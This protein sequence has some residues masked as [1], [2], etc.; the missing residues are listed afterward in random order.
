MRKRY[1]LFSLLI[2][3]AS[4]LFTAVAAAQIAVRIDV[5]DMQTTAQSTSLLLDVYFSVYDSS[6][7]SAPQ[8]QVQS[9]QILL[10]NGDVYDATV[11]RPPFY[12]ALLFDSSGSMKDVLP[13]MQEAGRQIINAAPAEAQFAVIQFDE[14]IV[15]QQTFTNDAAA[16][17]DAI[18]QI[19]VN[20]KGTCLYDGL[21][22]AVQSISQIAQDTPRQAV[23]VFTD[24]RDERRQGAG[25]SCSQN[26][27]DQLVAFAANRRRPVPI[28]P[29]GVAPAFGQLD[30]DILQGLATASGGQFQDGTKGLTEDLFTAILADLN[31]LW[32][33]QANLYP[34]QGSHR[35][36]LL[37]T[38]NDG[39]TPLPA[40]VAFTAERSYVTPPEPVTAVI[41]NFMYDN[42]SNSYFFDVS[43]TGY[44]RVAKIGAEVIDADTNQQITRITPQDV[45]WETE[46]VVVDA[47]LLQPDHTY[48]MRVQPLSSNGKPIRNEEVDG[49]IS[50]AATTNDTVTEVMA[51]YPFR[52]EPQLPLTMH[53]DS[54][55]I[56][57]D[58]PQINWQ[59][60]QVEDEPAQLTLSLFLENNDQVVQ[61]DGYILDNSNNQQIQTF[62]LT[63]LPDN[64]AQLP[65]QTEKTGTYT[66]VI[67]AL[68]ENGTRLAT[69]E[70]RFSYTHP[71]SIL[72]RAWES[73]QANPVLYPLGGAALLL[74]LLLGWIIGFVGGRINEHNRY[75]Q[76]VQKAMSVDMPVPDTVIQVL[77][78]RVAESLDTT[79]VSEAGQDISHFPYTIGREGCDLNIAGDQHISRKH[80]QIVLRDGSFYIEDEGSRNGTFVNETQVDSNTPFRLDIYSGSRIRVGKTTI[81]TLQAAA[82]GAVNGHSAAH[83]QTADQ[84]PVTDTTL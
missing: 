83:L 48:L 1:S 70:Y 50:D 63:L 26:T 10:E 21:Y 44:A 15:L 53:L 39:Q 5:G 68:D 40:P 45:S 49:E 34:T 61:Y 79:V 69:T 84:P 60:R 59:T 71:S 47:R 29:I 42:P 24:G 56:A 23:I 76:R 13:D 80:A 65:F 19:K 6:G 30:L 81:L 25:D 52:H 57:D 78:L 36:M 64:T 27:Y 55:A 16:A 72:V 17:L 28:Y 51:E 82:N 8:V 41:R 75:R 73:L 37:L 67:H 4:L 32:Q 74:V 33:A 20:N 14:S 12:V 54:I 18:D 22:T 58:K 3:F 43:L 38:L 62:T 7:R 66:A 31:S 2:L 9:A 11:S 46:R 35:G 77:H